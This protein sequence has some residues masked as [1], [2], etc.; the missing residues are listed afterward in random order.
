MNSKNLGF[1]QAATDLGLGDML[2]QQVED[3]TDDE[4][5]KRMARMQQQALTPA[6][7]GSAV[8]DLLGG[9]RAFS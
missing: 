4:R 7:S 8:M 9:M 3:E 1:S 2:R 5:K 6:G